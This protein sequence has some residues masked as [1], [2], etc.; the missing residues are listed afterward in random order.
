MRQ[1]VAVF[2]FFFKTNKINFSRDSQELALLGILKD[3]W[4]I[5]IPQLNSQSLKILQDAHSVIDAFRLFHISRPLKNKIGKTKR[6][7]FAN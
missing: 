2:F 7:A 4:G 1:F 3:S 6:I 5:L